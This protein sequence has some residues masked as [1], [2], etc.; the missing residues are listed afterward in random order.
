M[1]PLLFLF[2]FFG[3][4]LELLRRSALRLHCAATAGASRL[5]GVKNVRRGRRYRDGR[6]GRWD[7][8]GLVALGGTQVALGVARGRGGAI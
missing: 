4:P 2:S 5:D 6:G 8:G 7:L 1:S 3:T